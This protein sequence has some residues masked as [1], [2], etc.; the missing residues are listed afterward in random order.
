MDLT[1]LTFNVIENGKPQVKSSASDETTVDGLPGDFLL[2]LMTQISPL[3]REGAGG[4]VHEEAATQ[5]D[6]S[7]PLSGNEL[8]LFSGFL[9]NGKTTPDTF[10][11]LQ[12]ISLDGKLSKQRDMKGLEGSLNILPVEAKTR[13]AEIVTGETLELNKSLKLIKEEPQVLLEVKNLLLQ[14]EQGVR[15]GFHG[16]KDGVSSLLPDKLPDVSLASPLSLSKAENLTLARE[17]VP[18]LNRPLGQ[19]GWDRELSERIAW[20]AGKSVQIAELKLHPARLGPLEVHVQISKDQASVLFSSQHAVVR[21]ALE[22]AIPRL[23]EM[24]NGQQLSLVNVDISH[25]SF[26]ERQSDQSESLQEFGNGLEVELPDEGSLKTGT[27]QVQVT[28]GEGLLNYYV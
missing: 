27:T 18:A 2:T 5:Q 7:D 8:P 25:Q 9:V 28:S 10:A 17:L 19:E 13:P 21:E 12:V 11:D 14:R 16:A 22:L 24:M 1:S 26:S 15:I 20:M 4:F 23:K 3:E 6:I